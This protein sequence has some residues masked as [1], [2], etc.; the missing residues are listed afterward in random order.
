MDSLDN[1]IKKQCARCALFFELNSF[2]RY[3]KSQNSKKRGII[4]LELGVS[5]IYSSYCKECY[6]KKQRTHYNKHK[7]KKIKVAIIWNI[8][9]IERAR[10]SKRD[11]MR[12]KYASRNSKQ[13]QPP[14]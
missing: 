4:D 1:S 6:K 3:E 14:V 13:T 9:N 12:K 10:K 8:K 2:Y 5:Y 7:K 11:Y